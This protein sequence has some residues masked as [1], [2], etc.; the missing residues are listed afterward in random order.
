MDRVAIKAHAKESISG[1]IFILLAITIITSIVGGVLGFIPVVGALAAIVIAGPIE[2]SMTMIYLGIV[3]KNRAPK[4]EDIINGFK[5]NNFTRAFVAY[6]RYTIFTAL[7]SL[8]FVIPG[9]IK[10]ISYSQMFYLMAEDKK[11]DAAEAQRK[12]MEMME[13]HKWEYF[14][15]NLSFILWYMLVGITFGI[16]MIYV[17]P[18]VEASKAEFYR[19]LKK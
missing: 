14:M 8:L 15:L 18:Y 19:K 11:M 6:L 5:E 13:G 1:K 10:G 17:G 2:L 9:I 4:I 16:A 7:W 12:S 3:D